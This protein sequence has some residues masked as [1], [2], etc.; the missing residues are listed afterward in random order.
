MT[1]SLSAV[2]RVA[3]VLTRPVCIGARC[4]STAAVRMGRLALKRSIRFAAACDLIGR[5]VAELSD[6]PAGQEGRPS[7]SLTLDQSAALIKAS[8]WTRTGAYIA[9]SLGTGIR[10]E[11]A[12]TL[13][14][15]SVDFGDPHATPPRPPSVAVWR[16]VRRGGDTKTLRSRRTLRLPGFAAAALRDVQ[17]REDRDTGPVFATRDGR[18]LD[19]ANVRREIR[20]AVTAAGSHTSSRTTE[21]VYRHQLW[22]I[23]ENGAL[24]LDHLFEHTA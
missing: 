2:D 14:W 10:T 21:I 12:R 5:N 22:P 17:L 13:T 3:S 18:Q 9:V 7:R 8:S 4:Y 6:I 23:M 1:G 15:E 16:S 11:E 20:A 24:T 19:A